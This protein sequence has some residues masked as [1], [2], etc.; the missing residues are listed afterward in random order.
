[1]KFEN[2]L[3]REEVSDDDIVMLRS[4]TWRIVLAALYLRTGQYLP[5]DAKKR[6]AFFGFCDPEGN[7][8]PEGNPGA[9]HFGWSADRG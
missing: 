1:M 4:S 7:Y 3:P 9:T 8:L 5:D 6:G 2:V